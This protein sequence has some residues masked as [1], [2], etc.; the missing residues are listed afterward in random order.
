MV[1]GSCLMKWQCGQ[2]MGGEDGEEDEEV[3]MHR[4]QAS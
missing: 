2:G 3:I 1:W 4:L